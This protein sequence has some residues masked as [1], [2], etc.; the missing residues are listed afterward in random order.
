MQIARQISTRTRVRIPRHLKR[1]FCKHCG[2]F[3]FPSGARVRL[4]D[5]VLTTT[6]IGCGKQMRRPYR[7]PKEK[8]ARAKLETAQ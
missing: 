2:G 3:L 1:I 4:R 5:G 6:C 7:G 8:R